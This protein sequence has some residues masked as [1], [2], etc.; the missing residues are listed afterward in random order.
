[1][2]RSTTFKMRIVVG[3]VCD[4]V[5]SFLFICMTLNNRQAAPSKNCYLCS[6]LLCNNIVKY[7]MLFELLSQYICIIKYMMTIVSLFQCS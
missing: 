3:L 5:I 4:T 2:A 1:M 6:N 7:R